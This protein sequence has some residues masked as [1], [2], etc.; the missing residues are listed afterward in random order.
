MTEIE[1]VK[2]IKENI[3]PCVGVESLV[4]AINA[5]EKIDKI[6]KIIDCTIICNDANK[7]KYD[8][9]RKIVDRKSYRY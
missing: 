1:A 9:I 3:L 2:D 4:L 5:L 8:A 6:K 7:E